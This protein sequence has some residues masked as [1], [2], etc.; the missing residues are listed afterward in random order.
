VLSV[1]IDRTVRTSRQHRRRPVLHA[2]E[3][4]TTCLQDPR[5]STNIDHLGR[6]P[7]GE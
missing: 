4:D 7:A 1:G 6:V 5:C 2:S 3:G